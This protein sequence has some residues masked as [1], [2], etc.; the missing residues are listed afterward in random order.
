MQKKNQNGFMQ[1]KIGHF[2]EF[3]LNYISIGYFF[4]RKN[5][6]KANFLIERCLFCEYQPNLLFHFQ[7]QNESNESYNLWTQKFYWKWEQNQ[8]GW[9]TKNDFTCVYLLSDEW[10]NWPEFFYKKFYSVLF[11]MRM[12]TVRFSLFFGLN[13]IIY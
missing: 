1:A 9:A 2:L 5:L 3:S 6:R 10:D 8:I 4:G 7:L 11:F 12:Y 13:P